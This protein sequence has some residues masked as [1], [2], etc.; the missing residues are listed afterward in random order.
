MKPPAGYAVERVLSSGPTAT[1][2]LGTIGGGSGAPP[3]VLKWASTA[4]GAEAIDRERRALEALGGGFGV[5][6]L[7]AAWP[8]G[9]AIARIHGVTLA[10]AAPGLFA[11][12]GRRHAAVAATF[13]RLAALHDAGDARGALAFV[14]GDVSPDNVYLDPSGTAASIA[15]FGLSHWRDAPP[16]ADGVFRGTL[17]YAPPEIARGEP[18]DARADVFALA[19][20]LLHVALGVPLRDPGASPAALLVEAG[21][22]PFDASHPWARLAY[23]RFDQG[24]AA[25]LLGCLAFE[26]EGRPRRPEGACYCVGRLG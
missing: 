18:A 4:R 11:D 1:V 5:P 16:P 2:A 15:D 10:E 23:E 14:H 3:C 7:L 6:R 12:R 20:S 9:I 17:L 13:E 21:A 8:G 25:R 24:V 19:A 26:P 22:R